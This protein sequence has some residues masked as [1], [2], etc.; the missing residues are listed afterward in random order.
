M[1]YEAVNTIWP[2]ET[3]PCTR[4][5][6]ARAARKLMRHFAHVKSRWCRRCWVRLKP[7]YNDLSRGW[8][9]LVH[10]VSHRVHRLAQSWTVKDHSRTHAEIELEIARY[11]I[12]QG[13]LK[14]T[15][16]S[17]PKPAAKRDRAAHARAMVKRWEARQ[18][19]AKT[20]LAKWGRRVRY[21]E[22]KAAA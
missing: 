16:R 11:V 18:K 22:R 17:A 10:D 4:E 21:Y 6:A 5:E 13:W 19:R 8:P 15:L 20:A 1:D 9:R 7:P 2:A 14:G 12:D 3:P